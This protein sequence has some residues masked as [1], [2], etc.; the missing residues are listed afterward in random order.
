[1]TQSSIQV[2]TRFWDHESKAFD[3]IYSHKKTNLSNW[4]DR[5]FRSDMYGRFQFAMDHMQPIAN[6]TV[7]DLGCG[8]GRYAIPCA[9]A[10]ASRVLGIDIA[11][12]MLDMARQLAAE[13]GVADRCSFVQT[14][15]LNL[16]EHSKFDYLLAIGLF[17]YIQDPVPVLRKMRELTAERAIISFPRLWTWR[18]IPRKVRLTLRG[19]PV[20]FYTRKAIHQHLAEAGFT[21]SKIERVGKL[22]C[23]LAVPQV[24]STSSQNGQHH[25]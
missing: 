17:D 19:C 21:A 22:D 2:Q 24:K 6:R 15:V 9:T 3:A 4:M 7:L 5:V 25:S 18:A 11:P 13:N 10:G 16:D 12:R 23:V 20:Y 14:D 8:S 1:M